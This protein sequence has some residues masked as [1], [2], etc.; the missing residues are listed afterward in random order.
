MR[1][2][3]RA[4][5]RA[6]ALARSP[7]ALCRALA[8]SP[9]SSLPL[10]PIACSLAACTL[11][12]SHFLYSKGHCRFCLNHCLIVLFCFCITQRRDINEEREV[13]GWEQT[14]N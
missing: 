8:P 4:L 9:C 13:C 7:A 12:M 6:R 2:R 11:W 14:G 1:T 10:F 3:A 5:V